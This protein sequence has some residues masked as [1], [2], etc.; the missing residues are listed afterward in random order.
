MNNRGSFEFL[1]EVLEHWERIGKEALDYALL[2]DEWKS[3]KPAARRLL[4]AYACAPDV[5]WHEYANK[6][7]RTGNYVTKDTASKLLNDKRIQFMMVRIN[8]MRIALIIEW[9]NRRKMLLAMSAIEE[10]RKGGKGMGA[11]LTGRANLL[12]ELRAE[13]EALVKLFERERE[14]L[15]E[16]QKQLVGDGDEHSVD[17]SI[18]HSKTY[19]DES[20]EN[21]DASERVGR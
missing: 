11:L 3:L 21:F 9:L 19:G 8:L 10:G 5:Y 7:R 13:I 14:R 12:R 1:P 4:L 17:R 16:L 20:E 6:G 2:R 18:G 15:V